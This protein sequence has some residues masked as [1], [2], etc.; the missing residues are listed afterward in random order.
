MNQSNVEAMLRREKEKA[1]VSSICLE[2]KPPSSWMKNPS[3][4]A[5]PQ[6][7]NFDDRRENTLEH[8]VCFLDFVDAFTH[9][10][11]L[12]MRESSKSLTD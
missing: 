11:D 9:D 4:Y 8:V 6:F 7:Q 2:L 12:C 10:V 1:F 3:E 5:I